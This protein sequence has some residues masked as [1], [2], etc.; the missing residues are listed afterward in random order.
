MLYIW[1]RFYVNCIS[2]KLERIARDDL[3]PTLLGVGFFRL[4]AWER[5]G[6]GSGLL[7]CMSTC[8][9]WQ[10]IPGIAG[11]RWLHVTLVIS[12]V[13]VTTTKVTVLSFPPSL[14]NENNFSQRGSY[15][16]FWHQQ[17]CKVTMTFPCWTSCCVSHWPPGLQAGGGGRKAPRGRPR[18]TGRWQ[19][20]LKRAATSSPPHRFKSTDRLQFTL[21]RWPH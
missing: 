18:A 13:T 4:E 15:V 2:I 1:L 3:I 20:S 5:E 12:A 10:S 19:R 17:Q 11:S 14:S 9:C 7:T 16:S 21:T 8:Y 6:G